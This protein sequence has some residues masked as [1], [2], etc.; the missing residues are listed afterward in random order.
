MNTTT[1][2]TLKDGTQSP[3][4]WV[5]PASA[6][7]SPRARVQASGCSPAAGQSSSPFTRNTQQPCTTARRG[8]RGSKKI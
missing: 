7:S 6:G 8:W 3:A 2:I 5:K 1:T 4:G